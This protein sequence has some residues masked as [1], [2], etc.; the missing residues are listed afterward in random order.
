MPATGYIQVHAYSSYAQIPLEGVAVTVTADDGTAIA[1]R[2]TD[3]SGRITPIPLPVPDL[4]AS[5]SPDSGE[6]P[7]ATVNIHARLRGYEQI[8]A[9]RVQ[10]FA[11]T[12]T[13]QNL[14]M[15]PLAEL[16]GSWNQTEDFDTPP[17]NL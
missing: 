7:F 10:V 13:N 9:E 14:E 12:T 2:L 4:S 1:M 3:R 8:T 16:P 17:Q 11:D 15:I 5:Q 6:I